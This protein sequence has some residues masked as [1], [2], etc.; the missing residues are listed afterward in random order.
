LKF[1]KIQE[2][3]GT[4][5]FPEYLMYPVRKNPPLQQEFSVDN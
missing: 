5:V 4:A 2:Q 1:P 3:E